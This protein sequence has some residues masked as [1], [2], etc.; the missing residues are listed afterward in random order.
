MT[1]TRIQHAH[2][3]HFL[4]S[5]CSATKIQQSVILDHG[6]GDGYATTRFIQC[7]AI[8]VD[9]TDLQ[10]TPNVPN[11]LKPHQ[12]YP[13]V[14]DLVWSHHVIEH[15]ENPVKYLRDLYGC[16]KWAVGELWL[17]C[18]NTEG[19]AVFAEGHL[20]NFNLG[21]LVQ[22]LKLAGFTTQSMSWLVS[23]GQLRIRVPKIK[24]RPEYPASFIKAFHRNIHFSISQQPAI[25]RW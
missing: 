10:I 1:D 22:C 24:I 4:K 17:G 19:K 8:H 15:Q 6:C 12:I 23:A 2:T 14:Y 13:E 9:S 20:C 21:N 5:F 16:L 18:P 3:D 25:W 7:G 11:F